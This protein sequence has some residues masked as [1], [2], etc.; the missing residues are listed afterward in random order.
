VNPDFKMKMNPTALR[1]AFLLAALLPLT[2]ALVAADPAAAPAATPTPETALHE[3][4]AAP[5]APALADAPTPVPTVAQASRHKADQDEDD[6]DGDN[7]SDSGRK[8]Q[9]HH[10][11]NDENRVAVGDAAVVEANETV[12]GNAVSVFGPLTVRGTVNGNAVAVCGSSR[13]DGTVHGNAVV[14][15]GT[16]RLGSHAHVDG[17]VVAGVGMVSKD[18]GAYVGGSTV[19]QG[20]RLDFADDSEASNWWAHGLRMGRPL[21]LGHGLHVFWFINVCLVVLYVFL[22]LVFPEGARKCG[23]TLVKRPGITFLTGILAMIA[24]P[25]VFVLLC[26]TIVGIPVALIVLPLA[27]MSCMVFGRASLYALVGRSILGKDQHPALAVLVGALV[28]MLVYLIPLIGIAVWIV[29]SFLGFACALTTLVSP[30]KPAVPVLPVVPAQPV[31]PVVPAPSPVAQEGVPPE[32]A[33]LLVPPVMQ[34]IPAA[35]APAPAPIAAALVQASEAALPR[36]GFW[37]RMVALL[38]DAILIGALTQMSHLVLPALAAYGAILWKHKGS[39]IGGIIF[40]IKVVRLDSRPVDWM[41]AVVRALAC[42]ISL[43]ALGLGFI[44]IAFDPEKQGWHD[45]IAGTV[46]VR[47]PKG[48]SLV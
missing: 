36:A 11:D 45:K 6:D 9:R 7:D 10:H 1:A 19:Q 28:V 29:V 46:V 37:I 14:V 42:F 4:G 44:W 3:I 30:N 33:P 34:S 20:A 15:F 32:I 17:N 41:T 43:I 2:A 18:P 22:A 21:A 39:T 5:A 38:I 27:V 47:L 16:L 48:V 40:G 13:I 31:I 24:L 12:P 26:I 8:W 35:A 25:V 23:D